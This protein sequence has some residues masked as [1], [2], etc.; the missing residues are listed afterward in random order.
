MTRRRILLYLSAAGASC[1]LLA[2]GRLIDV[3]NL[4][5]EEEG[6]EVFNNLLKAHPRT[7]VAVAVDSVDEIYRSESLPRVWG[8][9]RNEMIQRR[10]RQLAHLSPYR[11]AM[12]QGREKGTAN[13]RYLL[14]GL[15][16]PEQV[17]VW[18]EIVHLRGSPLAGLW[19]LPSLSSSLYQRFKLQDEHLLLVSEQTGGLRL[20]YLERG[21]LRFSRLAP[22]DSNQYEDPLEGYADEIGRTRLALVGQRLIDREA[23]IKVILLDPLGTLGGLS[24][25]LL[26]AA[27]FRCESIQRGRLIEALAL[28]PDLLAESTD[29]LYLRLLAHAPEAANLMTGEQRASFRAFLLRASLR[30]TAMLWLAA[31]LGASLL[32]GLDIWRLEHGRAALAQQIDAQRGEQTALLAA[33]GGAEALDRRLTALD[34]WNTL[35]RP[36][37]PPALV[38]VSREA[39]AAGLQLTRLEW[40]NAPLPPGIVVEGELRDHRGDYRAA[41]ARLSAFAERLRRSLPRHQVAITTWPLDTAP[42][43]ALEG[44]SGQGARPATYRLE[45]TP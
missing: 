4:P 36:E 28:P 42:D 27:G 35:P 14:L 15:T 3:Q 31:S 30:T 12:R 24:T 29:A 43:Q 8:S 37:L 33:V 9:D 17:R 22:V 7:P 6:W 1:A 23:G 5:G 18:L 39:Q 45:I 25:F 16:N 38:T 10:L 26:E 34:A 19:L 13:D 44:E 41:H 2:G 40:Q 21:E 11:T 32:L 20:S